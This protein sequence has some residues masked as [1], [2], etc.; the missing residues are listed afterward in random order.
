[1]TPSSIKEG[2]L[3]SRTDDLQLAG[4]LADENGTGGP[5]IPVTHGVQNRFA[6]GLLAECRNVPNEKTVLKMLK[7]VAEVDGIP[8]GVVDAEESLPIFD[9]LL[10]GTGCFRRAVL[11]DD[12]CLWQKFAE[13]L[14]AAEEDQSCIRHLFIDDQFRVGEELAEA[15]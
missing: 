10:G 14:S 15:V 7:V 5:V 6:N 9:P 11:E 3:S 13:A 4:I 1:M 8:Q 12:F 2:S